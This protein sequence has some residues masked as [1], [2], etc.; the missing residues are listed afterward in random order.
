MTADAL[1]SK[2]KTA[3]YFADKEIAYALLGAMETGSPL[4]VEG[5]P[6]VGKSSLAVALAQAENIPLVRVQCYEGISPETILYD[7]IISASFLLYL[8]FVISSMKQ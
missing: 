8:L 6:G 3:D 7:T 5:D 1:I 2:L 4:L